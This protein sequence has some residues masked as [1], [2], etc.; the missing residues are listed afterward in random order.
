MTNGQN[1]L[2]PGYISYAFS[3]KLERLLA[4]GPHVLSCDDLPAPV[5]LEPGVCPDQASDV[6]PS[7]D[8]FPDGAF[9]S[10]NEGYVVAKEVDFSIVQAALACLS[11]RSFLSFERFRL[12]IALSIRRRTLKSSASMVCTIKLWVQAASAH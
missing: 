11:L 3:V 5:P 12:G 4:I 6:F 7:I 9:T 8:P 10:V 1:A 2:T